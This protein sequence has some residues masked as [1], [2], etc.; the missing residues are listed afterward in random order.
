MAVKPG[1]DVAF[2]LQHP[3]GMNT[4]VTTSEDI[5]SYGQ[6]TLEELVERKQQN[7]T[8]TQ[9]VRSNIKR[10]IGQRLAHEITL[11]QFRSDHSSA[12]E[13]QSVLQRHRL[14]LSAEI[15]QRRHPSPLAGDRSHHRTH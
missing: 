3:G 1:N 5:D 7:D 11:E 15:W 10:I 4:A 6:L 12:M 14:R 9:A 13:L 2:R 8:A